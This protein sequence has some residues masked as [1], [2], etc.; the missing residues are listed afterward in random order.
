MIEIAKLLLEIIGGGAV[1]LTI[2]AVIMHNW[3]WDWL[4]KHGYS[5]PVA[6]LL[7]LL[8]EVTD[9]LRKFFPGSKAIIMLDEA[10]DEL[11]K[12]AGLTD[13]SE[14]RIK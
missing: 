6:L 1:S 4:V 8:D 12:G 10:I 9:I 3:G 2:L 5:R 13:W 14:K 11:I 7:W